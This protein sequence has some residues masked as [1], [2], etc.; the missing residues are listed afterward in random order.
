MQCKYDNSINIKKCHG[1]ITTA[2]GT[3]AIMKILKVIIIVINQENC[4][5]SNP[6]KLNRQ[7]STDSREEVAVL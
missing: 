4:S 3:T 5:R 1:D 6:W 2:A 7:E